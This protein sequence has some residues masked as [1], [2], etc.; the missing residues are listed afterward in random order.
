MYTYVIYVICYYTNIHIHVI[1]NNV[2]N[3]NVYN[4]GT[5]IVM[6]IKSVCDHMH[7]FMCV[8]VCLVH[9]ATHSHI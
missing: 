1:Y 6:Y 9:L 4:I 5:F 7:A 8:H 2:Y 3:Y